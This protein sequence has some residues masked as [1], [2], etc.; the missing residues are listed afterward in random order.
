MAIEAGNRVVTVGLIAEDS[1]S[2]RV[3]SVDGDT[4]IVAWDTGVVTPCDIANL[5]LESDD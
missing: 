3:V 5:E 4:A 1:D 2:G